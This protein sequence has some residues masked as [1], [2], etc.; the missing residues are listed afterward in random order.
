M[1]SEM[2]LPGRFAGPDERGA[3]S[4][5]GLAVVLGIATLAIGGIGVFA[6]LPER[7]A[8][9]A[10]ADSAALTAANAAS[11]RIQGYPCA[12]AAQ[13]TEVNGADLDSCE[14]QGLYVTVTV[15]GAVLGITVTVASR[16]GPPPA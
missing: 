2:H 12:L 9:Q 15:S 14:L 6:A 5:L 8:L 7:N 13:A 10:A 16:A 1:G 4:V 3:G 11:G